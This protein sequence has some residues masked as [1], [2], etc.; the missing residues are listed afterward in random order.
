MK[1]KNSIFISVTVLL[2]SCNHQNV[3]EL[4][5]SISPGRLPYLKTS[6]MVQVAS[7]DSTGGNN[8]RINIHAGKIVTFA[9]LDGP[10]VITRIWI[11]IDSRDPHFLRRI[12]LRFYWDGEESPSIEVPVGYFFGT[13]LKLKFLSLSPEASLKFALNE[14][15]KLLHA[16]K[17]ILSA[18]IS[19]ALLKFKMLSFKF[20]SSTLL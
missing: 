19:A 2:I 17:P 14:S 18:L 3:S 5:N 1:L 16:K 4:E 6:K 8:D 7:F 13:G 15:S 11:T 9:K 12:L 20:L 10:G